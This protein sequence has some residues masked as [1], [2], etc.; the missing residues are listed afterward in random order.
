VFF[1]IILQ[2]FNYYSTYYTLYA[3]K[4]TC[5]SYIIIYRGAVLNLHNLATVYNLYY[6][7]QISIYTTHF[8]QKKKRNTLP[9]RL[10][11]FLLVVVRLSVLVVKNQKN[12]FFSFLCSFFCVCVALS[13]ILCHFLATLCVALIN[14]FTCFVSCLYWLILGF[15]LCSVILED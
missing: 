11:A 14:C 8:Q 3:S 12:M 6:L 15:V 7:Q 5:N 1:F 10:G 9:C 2:H 4:I 13:L